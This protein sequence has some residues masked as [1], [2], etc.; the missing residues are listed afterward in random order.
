MTPTTGQPVTY[1]HDASIARFS[2]KRYQAM[3]ETGILTP[4]D[5]VELLENWVVLKMPRSPEHDSTIQQMMRPLIRVIPAGFDLRIQSAIALDDS[6]PEP[7]H[8]V[9]RGRAAD[10]RTRHP[11][12]GDIA[13]LI[14][15]A[16]SSILRDQ[17]DKAR[18]YA[19]AGIA[20]YW[21]V[22]LPDCRIEVHEQPSGPTAAPAYASVR[23]FVPGDDVPLP[24]G[25]T[26][27]AAE[28]LP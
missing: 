28:L 13:L 20:V 8:A 14:E 1:G 2:V 16:H 10:Y 19:R 12:P 9:V 4:D 22:N 21:I 24:F 18:L 27:P 17:R 23:Y 26:L 25:G 15:V 5:H 11:R 7:D 3:I 6:Q